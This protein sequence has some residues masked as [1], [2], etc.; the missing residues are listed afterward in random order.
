[1]PGSL[2]KHPSKGRIWKLISQVRRWVQ[3]RMWACPG[4][5]A[6]ERLETLL[7]LE[8][9]VGIL[10]DSQETRPIIGPQPSIDL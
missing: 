10:P 8:G 2:P 3:S 9:M 1:M 7:T 5:G 6:S 4:L